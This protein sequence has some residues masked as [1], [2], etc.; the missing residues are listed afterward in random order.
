MFF[1]QG[2]SREVKKLK[3][4]AYRIHN[5]REHEELEFFCWA[6]AAWANRPNGTDSMEG[7]FV[8]MSTSRLRQGFE[9]NV[10]PIHWHSGKIERTCRS[11][12]CAEV[13][14]CLDGE[15]ELTSLRLLWTGMQ[16]YG[17]TI[18]TRKIDESIQYTKGMLITDA[19]NLFDKLIRP[20]ASVKGAEKRSSIE[21]LSLRENLERNS[22]N[23]L[24]KLR[25]DDSQFSD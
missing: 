17:Y 24:G 9:G 7:I 16:G 1:I 11:P 3:D 15:D 5:F 14:G 2:Y 20:T 21:A 6:D 22:R 10:S 23:T 25:C 12:A 13:M 18:N 8:G 4:V 19:R